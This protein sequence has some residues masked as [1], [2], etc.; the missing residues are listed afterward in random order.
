MEKAQNTAQIGLDEDGSFTV[1]EFTALNVVAAIIFYIMFF[2]GLFNTTLVSNEQNDLYDKMLWFAL[3][4]A[5]YFTLK[6]K[7]KRVYIRISNEGVYIND[8][9]LSDWPHFVSA[10]Y[11]QNQEAGDLRDKFVLII[12]YYRDNEGYYVKEVPL[13]N[14]Q[15]KAEEEVIAAI[16]H[17]YSL[18]KEH[19]AITER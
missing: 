8:Y 16:N 10:E 18:H 3:A 6:A 2:Y 12:N 17:F 7:S 5:I 9:F 11:T 4:P 19:M 13:T 15:N 14:T 1:K